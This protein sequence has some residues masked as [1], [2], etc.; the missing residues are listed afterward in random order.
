MILVR[1]Q[2]AR[3]LNRWGTI[4]DALLDVPSKERKVQNQRNPV[5]IDEEEEGEESMDG[6]FGDDIGVEA[7]AQIDGVDVV[8]RR[9][10]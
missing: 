8:T 10:G 9:R 3:F 2:L 7:V 6:G 1:A 4:L 5:A